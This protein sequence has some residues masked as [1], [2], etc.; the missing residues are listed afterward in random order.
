MLRL[1]GDTEVLVEIMKEYR[2]HIKARKQAFRVKRIKQLWIWMVALGVSYVDLVGTIVVGMEY[3]A[4]GAQASLGAACGVPC[5]VLHQ[6]MV[7]YL[8]S[9][10]DGAQCEV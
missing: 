10:S 5:C 2:T 9:L 7:L 1:D 6:C 8:V 4:A 3:W